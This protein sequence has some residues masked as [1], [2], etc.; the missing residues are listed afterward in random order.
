MGQGS[1]G[2]RY[3]SREGLK[4]SIRDKATR[5]SE[6]RKYRGWSIYK[7]PGSIRKSEDGQLLYDNLSLHLR[8]SNYV[9]TM[10]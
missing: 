1:V 8:V 2:E 9:G 5:G 3:G 7:V 6:G 10:Y 4:E